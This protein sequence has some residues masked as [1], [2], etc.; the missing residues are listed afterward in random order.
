M[1]YAL[2]Q[3]IGREQGAGNFELRQ[4]RTDSEL[5]YSLDTQLKICR[6]TDMLQVEE[7]IRYS[8]ENLPKGN[9]LKIKISGFRLKHM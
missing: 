1:L 5:R 9:R 2:Q 4:Q 6:R 7:L 8:T 3:I